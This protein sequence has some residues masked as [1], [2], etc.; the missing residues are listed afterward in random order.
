ML[1]DKQREEFFTKGYTRASGAVPP[2]VAAA[3]VSRI[4]R[5]LEER[6]GMSR[7]DPTTWIAG[8][9]RGIGDL[10]RESEFRPFGSP[11]IRTVIDE[12]LGEGGW[13][14]PSSWGQILATFPSAEWSWNSLF[15][16]QV[17]VS[18]ITWHNDYPYDT[19]PDE[20]SGVQIFGLLA[21]LSPG[22]GGTLVIEGSHRLVRNFIRRQPPE[23]IQKM[24]RARKALLASHPWFH[25]VS[26]A[27]SLPRPEAW[28]ARQRAV[29]DDISIAVSEL[30]GNAG[31]VYFT[32][33]WLLH[34]TS[35]NCNATPRLMCT[36]RIRSLAVERP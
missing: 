35:P 12:L 29:I 22:G 27:V 28:L 9:V 32:H 1:T 10:N 36:Q 11:V 13:Q 23:T 17:D 15:Q 8:G 5:A 25:E 4:W 34:A 19:P 30:T 21:D 31:D 33:P 20:L 6:Q 7:N 24:K 2:D 16:D 14:M 26:S 18:T 3:M